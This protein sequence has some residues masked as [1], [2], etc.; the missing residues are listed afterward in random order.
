MTV[1]DK[2]LPLPASTTGAEWLNTIEGFMIYT[3]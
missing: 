2:S 3:F 1:N